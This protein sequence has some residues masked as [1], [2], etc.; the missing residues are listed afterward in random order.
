MSLREFTVEPVRMTYNKLL[1]KVVP[2]HHLFIVPDP[3]GVLGLC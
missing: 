2:F 1:Q 3:G